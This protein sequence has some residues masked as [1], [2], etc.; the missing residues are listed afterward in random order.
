MAE[1]NVEKKK[2]SP[3]GWIILAVVVIGL[4]IWFAASDNDGIQETATNITQD[5][6]QSSTYGQEQSQ[7]AAPYDA[8]RG[9]SETNSRVQE[10]LTFVD[11]RTNDEM[12]QATVQEGINKLSD[13]LLAISNEQNQGQDNL[14]GELEQIKQQAGQLQDAN[15]NEQ[16]STAIRSAFSS[17]ANVIQNLQNRYYPE[18]EGDASNVLNAA[19]DIDDQ[20]LASE[21]ENEIQ[22]FFEESASIIEKMEQKSQTT[23]LQ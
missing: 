21:Q 10:Y 23:S 16:H 5:E 13:A 11:E 1:L 4:I 18:L 12:D 8:D 19:Q 20:E 14:G 9:R 2:K 3:I 22:S 15:L 7:A 17:A 6:E